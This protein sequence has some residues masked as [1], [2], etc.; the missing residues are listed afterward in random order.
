MDLYKIRHWQENVVKYHRM[1]THPTELFEEYAQQCTLNEW[2]RIHRSNPVYACWM[3]KWTY[4]KLWLEPFQLSLRD[5]IRTEEGYEDLEYFLENQNKTGSIQKLMLNNDIL[6][7]TIAPVLEKLVYL[8]ELNVTFY[9][10]WNFPPVK[11][12][13]LETLNITLKC[14]L[15]VESFESLE[16]LPN[17]KNLTIGG[18]QLNEPMVG[19]IT[20]FSLISLNLHNVEIDPKT[21]IPGNLFLQKE[22]ITIVK[23]NQQILS[24]LLKNLENGIE[25]LIFE[26]KYETDDLEF[27]KLK[28][29]DT[30]KFIT[31]TMTIENSSL[32]GTFLRII[33]QIPKVQQCCWHINI[34]LTESWDLPLEDLR[35]NAYTQFNEHIRSTIGKLLFKYEHVNFNIKE[36]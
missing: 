10:R 12:P 21:N 35:F 7:P 16:G 23:C 36:F 33:K 4:F 34:T 2:F 20:S 6:T 27:D 8:S 26:P 22:K 17:L 29:I 32:Y 25:R 11:F 9:G 5:Y 14:H 18:G 13:C 31:I 30:L 28:E 24:S 15:A 1:T 3:L 19:F